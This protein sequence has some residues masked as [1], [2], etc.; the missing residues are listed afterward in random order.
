METPKRRQIIYL[1]F[2]LFFFLSGCASVQTVQEWQKIKSFAIERTGN[3]IIWQKSEEDEKKIKEEINKLLSDNLTMDDSVRIALINNKRLQAAFEEIGIAKADLVQAGL[4]TNPDLSA[5]FRF[6]LGGGRTG[7]ETG[8][9]LNVSDIWQIPIK[10]KIASARLE[11]TLNQISNEILNTVKDAKSAYIDYTALSLIRDEME[12]MKD[13]VDEWR[14]HIIYRERFGFSSS[15][16]VYMAEGIATEIEL[17]FSKIESELLMAK[18]K[19]NRVMG[20]SYNHDFNIVIALSEEVLPLP[21]LERLISQ[22]IAFRPDLQ[23]I[24]LEV[25]ESANILSL[26]RSR[27]FSN[28]RT[29]ILY[30]KGIEG[31]ESMDA[32]IGIQLPIFDQNQAQIAKAEY[33]FRQKEKELEAKIK[34]ISEEV[35]IT[36]ERISF[37]GQRINS[38]KTRIIP[39]R[40]QALR[41]AERYFN[42]MELNMLYLLEAQQKLLETKKHYFNA[43]KEYHK[44]TIEL[45]RIIGR[46]I[47]KAL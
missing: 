18:Y 43:L 6:P 2:A 30:E 31:D 41:F 44:Q 13:A 26:E 19:L 33:R 36:Y 20:L 15:L 47:A 34:E 25:E 28:V 1:L 37:L 40:K 35:S 8:G 7:V 42:A 10:K 32:E 23:L 22:A 14:D 39:G 46:V 5:I 29:G 16:D 45:E 38:L 27:I 17:E 11:M 4:F 9:L 12:R 24:K 3:E 21:E